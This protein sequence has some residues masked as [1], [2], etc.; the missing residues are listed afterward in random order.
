VSPI[1]IGEEAS[2]PKG[3]ETDTLEASITLTLNSKYIWRGQ[4]VV[5][6]P[7]VQ[8]ESSLSYRGLTGTVWANYDTDEG[9]EWTEVDYTLDCTTSLASSSLELEWI[10]LSVGYTYY[11][12]PPLRH[13]VEAGEHRDSHEVY[14]GSS[15]ETLLS[16]YVAIYYD[17]D[18]GDGF[19]YELGAEQGFPLG[20]A[21]LSVGGSAGYNAGQ[22]G[23]DSSF[24]AGVL[25][26][27]LDVPLTEGLSWSAVGTVSL[28]L[29][30]QYD[31]E[32]FAGTSVAITF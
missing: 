32:F 22:W 7:V 3:A 26:M 20:G 9:Q 31:D 1:A 16:P 19:Y 30:D 14:V 8:P 4:N 17:F 6:G 24:G 2:Q 28:A 27:R 5:D 15:L 29:D 23:Y 12:F 21:E 13:H 10:S 11:T 25:S 18:Q